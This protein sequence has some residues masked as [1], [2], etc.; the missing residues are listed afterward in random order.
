MSN[1]RSEAIKEYIASNK[2]TVLLLAL[3]LFGILMLVFSSSFFSQ[4]EEVGGVSELEEY[5]KELEAELAD[6][7]SSVSGVGRCRVMLTFERGE[8]NIYKGS[9]LLESR[10]PKVM[11]VTVVCRGADSD[12]VRSEIVN[13]MM[14]LFDIGANRISVLKFN[15]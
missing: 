5:K 12:T 2:K 11:G 7:C 1:N 8:E 13:M 14:A 6:I 10:P 9:A 15:S 4:K 3:S